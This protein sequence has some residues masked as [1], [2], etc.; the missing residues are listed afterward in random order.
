MS[1]SGLEEI[2]SPEFLGVKKILNRK[3]ISINISALRISCL[4]FLRGYVDD[5]KT[6]MS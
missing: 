2:M 1:R 3:N 4:E 5:V 6:I